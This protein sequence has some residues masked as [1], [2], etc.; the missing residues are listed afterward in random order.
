MLLFLLL[1]VYEEGVVCGHVGSYY[2][3]CSGLVS[4]A[5]GLPPPSVVTQQMQGNFCAKL[6]NYKEL[7]PGDAILKP[8]QHVEMFIRWSDEAKDNFIEAGCHNS[9]ENCSHRE[10]SISNYI[11]KA[12]FG[13][14]PHS[15]YVCGGSLKV[16]TNST[17]SVIPSI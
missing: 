4:Y 15:N 8:D 3:D 9:K 14:R 6:G 5:W 7:M 11:G 10:V 16:A 13:C 17:D 1:G 2:C 12:Y